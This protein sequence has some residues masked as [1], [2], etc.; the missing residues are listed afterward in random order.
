VVIAVGDHYFGGTPEVLLRASGPL[1]G[2]AGSCYEEMCGIL[3]GGLM[4]L[5]A[6]LGRVSPTE[7]DEAI[8]QLSRDYRDR[9]R[10]LAG[11]TQCQAIRDSLPEEEKRC[12]PIVVD[13]VRI[14]VEMLD[15]K[16]VTPRA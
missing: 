7:D 15:A 16:G 12:E 4:M 6:L 11:H 8:F 2:G 10:A 9:F 14:L 13:A 1:A 5:G 3:S